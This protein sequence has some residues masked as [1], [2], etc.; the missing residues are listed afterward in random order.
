MHERE[1][2]T[3]AVDIGGTKISAAL[4]VEGSI[5]ERRRRATPRSGDPDALVD[6]IRT[7][8]GD[9]QVSEAGLAVATT[10]L[11]RDG[12]LFSVNPSVLPLPDGYTA[13]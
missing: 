9:W 1:E 12:C 3:V 10:G 6:A 7:L 5:L 2:T 13:R 8:L 4:V 11:V